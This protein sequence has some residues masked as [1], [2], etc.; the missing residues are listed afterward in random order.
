MYTFLFCHSIFVE[1]KNTDPQAEQTIKE[2]EQRNF[3]EYVGALAQELS[4]EGK[5]AHAR[6]LAG[7]LIKNALQAK[8]DTLQKEKHQRWTSL[9]GPIRDGIKFPLLGAMRSNEAVVAHIAA[10]AAAVDL[11][12]DHLAAALPQGQLPRSR[13]AQPTQRRP[14]G[15]PPGA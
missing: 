7:L 6:Q 1:K 15:E 3:S 8:D 5:P 2:W 14:A 11:V 9:D 13:R 4:T 10:V 12:G